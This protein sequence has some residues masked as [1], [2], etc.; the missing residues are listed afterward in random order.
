MGKESTKKTQRTKCEWHSQLR[1]LI[2]SLIYLTSQPSLTRIAPKSCF[3]KKTSGELSQLPITSHL[4]TRE[5]KNST[6]YPPVFQESRSHSSHHAR[7]L[8]SHDCDQDSSWTRQ[9]GW[10]TRSDS[11]TRWVIVGVTNENGLIL[12]HIYVYNIYIY[13]HILYRDLLPDVNCVILFVCVSRF[14][15]LGFTKIDLQMCPENVW[16]TYITFVPG[17]PLAGTAYAHCSAVDDH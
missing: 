9:V 3:F 14:V 17:L 7:A 15:K 11:S 10:Q 2:R 13:I 5:K 8:A 4:E 16:F 12:M 1:D 6:A